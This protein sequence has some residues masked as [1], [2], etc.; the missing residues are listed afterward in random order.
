[1][2]LLSSPIL[3]L[4]TLCVG[5][6][7][8]FPVFGQELSEESIEESARVDN[9]SAETCCEEAA[10]LRALILTIER[11]TIDPAPALGACEA[12][13]HLLPKSVLSNVFK[14]EAAKNIHQGSHHSVFFEASHSKHQPTPGPQN[15][16]SPDDRVLGSAF[17]VLPG[18]IFEYITLPKLTLEVTLLPGFHTLPETP[19]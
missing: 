5:V 9:Y 1:M 19:G 10:P 3:R 8:A 16:L 6:W 13:P 17:P 2:K 14:F 12:L 7:F 4:L 11:C 18:P 15:T